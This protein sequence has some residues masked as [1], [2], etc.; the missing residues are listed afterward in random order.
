M[1]QRRVRRLPAVVAAH[2]LL[3]AHI[4]VLILATVVV[5]VAVTLATTS[6]CARMTERAPEEEALQQQRPTNARF[7]I[8]ASGARR[9]GTRRRR[10][11]THRSKRIECRNRTSYSTLINNFH[12]FSLRPTPLMKSR[13]QRGG[14]TAKGQLREKERE[15]N[16]VEDTEVCEAHTVGT[17][18]GDPAC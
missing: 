10:L 2:L 7:D 18:G 1:G 9:N 13:H 17:Q 14:A 8:E 4:V 5:V 6:H 11:C 12:L 15:R 16:S 3:V